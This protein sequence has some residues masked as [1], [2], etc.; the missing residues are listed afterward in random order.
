[1]MMFYV[2]ISLKV[3]LYIIKVIECIVCVLAQKPIGQSPKI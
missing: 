3:L 1:M 2:K